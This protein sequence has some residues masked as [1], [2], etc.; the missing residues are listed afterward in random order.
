MLKSFEHDRDLAGSIPFYNR[1][2]VSVE[3]RGYYVH[4][5]LVK[6]VA[7]RASSRYALQIYELLDQM[8]TTEREEVES[9]IKQQSRRMVPKNHEHD[10]RYHIWSESSPI[11][12]NKATLHLVRRSNKSFN[13]VCQH[14]EN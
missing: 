4:R 5:L 6:A 2:N 11:N 3:I 8:A 7:M 10:S 14:Y 12:P 9:T 13:S 1:I